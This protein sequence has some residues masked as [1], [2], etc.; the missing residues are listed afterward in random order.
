MLVPG[1]QRLLLCIQAVI[2]RHKF[3]CLA[4][5][6]LPGEVLAQDGARL[7]RGHMY[8]EPDPA[9]LNARLKGPGL[10]Y[11]TQSL[12]SAVLLS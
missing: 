12:R 8:A 2:R 6:A 10:L 9:G 5:S 1:E 4:H 11:S 7:M 3:N